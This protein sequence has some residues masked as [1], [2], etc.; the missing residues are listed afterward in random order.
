M[1][2]SFI[3]IL[4]L[5]FMLSF[6][7]SNAFAAKSTDTY[8]L[9]PTH[10]YV[11][12]QIKHLGFSMQSGKWY[13]TGT[14]ILDKYKPQNSEVNAV[15]QV[16]NFV[17]GLPDLDEHLK[18]SQFFDVEKYPTATFVSKKIRVTG[19][20]KAIMY[21]ELTLHGVTKPV[22]LNVTLNKEGV[23]PITNTPTVGF[24]ATGRIKRSDFNMKT[25]LP[26]LGDDVDLDIEIEANRPA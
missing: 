25:L 17:T 16:A 21:G 22:M 20:N 24:S 9:D 23:N 8:T 2:S 15:I 12:W 4:F 11:L 1:K 3:R 18:G 7:F 13:A 6:S 19:K 26:L 10:S 14:L 5:L